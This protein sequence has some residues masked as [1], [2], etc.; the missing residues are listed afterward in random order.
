MNVKNPK[1]LVVSPTIPPL[2]SLKSYTRN[3]CTYIYI[4]FFIIIIFE[5][6]KDSR[7]TDASKVKKP[8][9]E[10]FT[11]SWFFS[12]EEKISNTIVRVCLI[13]GIFVVGKDFFEN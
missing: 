2:L 1:E 11:G 12:K 9:A 7:K 4:L 5:Y 10:L 8:D 13:M 3:S 6:K